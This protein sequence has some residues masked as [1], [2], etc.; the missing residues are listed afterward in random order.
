MEDILMSSI[1]K[2]HNKYTFNFVCIEVCMCMEMH[3]PHD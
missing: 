3:V 1:L 2:L